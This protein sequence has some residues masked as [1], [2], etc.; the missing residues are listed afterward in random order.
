VTAAVSS[1]E[2]G[3]EGSDVDD[4]SAF[5]SGASAADAPEPA[6]EAPAAPQASEGKLPSLDDALARVP[7]GVLGLLD[8]LFRAKFTGVR[9]Y[10]VP[11]AG[12]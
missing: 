6:R 11:P 12:R 9:Q 8:D 3:P 7:S 5:L 10:P 4:E 2:P 1:Q